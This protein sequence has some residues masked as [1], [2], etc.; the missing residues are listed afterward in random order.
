LAS[1][2]CQDVKGLDVP[3]NSVDS[4]SLISR[5]GGIILATPQNLTVDMAS[6]P[7]RTVIWDKNNITAQ[8]FQDIAVAMEK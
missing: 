2:L 6:F 3:R 5:G 1:V 7:N 8:G 4:K